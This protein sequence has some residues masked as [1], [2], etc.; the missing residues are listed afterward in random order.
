MENK[1]YLNGSV[2]IP[3]QQCSLNLQY[4]RRKTI[5]FCFFVNFRQALLG[6]VIEP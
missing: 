1:T 2:S 3:N 4:K 6:K 5:R